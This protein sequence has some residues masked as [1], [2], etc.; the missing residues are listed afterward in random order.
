MI[1]LSRLIKSQWPDAPSDKKV[2]SIKLFNIPEVN[3]DFS[4]KAAPEPESETSFQ[5]IEEALLEAD[6]I[7]SQAKSEAEQLFAQAQQARDAWIEERELLINQAREEGY[8]AG[9]VQGETKGY[10]EYQEKLQ[11]AEQIIHAAQKDYHAYLDTSENTILELAVGIA[12]KI[13]NQKIE[14]D[15]GYF[16]SL[17][18]KAVREVKEFQ[19]VEIHVHPENYEYL[20]SKKEEL[21]AVFPHDTTLFIYPDSDLSEGSCRLESP[22]GRIDASIDTQ[23]SEIKRKL[24]EWLERDHHEGS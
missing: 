12:E 18:K 16:L 21:L 14:D 22:Y 9:W 23:V 11:S 19:E 3:E 7:K 1:S 5:I 13:V 10:S 20:L 6:R 8:S 17:V 4:A 24:S 2:I 15:H